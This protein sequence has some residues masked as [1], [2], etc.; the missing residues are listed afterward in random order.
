MKLP[1]LKF[2]AKNKTHAL[3]NT[4]WNMIARCYIEIAP[5]LKI[6]ALAAFAYRPDG[7][8]LNFLQKTWGKLNRQV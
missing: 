2:S 8:I 5:G 3:Y 7:K 4:W 1:L 6:T